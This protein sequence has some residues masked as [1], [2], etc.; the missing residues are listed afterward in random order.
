MVEKE[1]KR[2]NEYAHYEQILALAE[3]SSENAKQILNKYSG[4][5]PSTEEISKLQALSL[6]NATLKAKMGG[7]LSSEEETRY[8]TLKTVFSNGEPSEDE[9]LGLESK[10]NALNTAKARKQVIQNSETFKADS[11]LLRFTKNLPSAEQLAEMDGLANEHKRISEELN[12]MRLGSESTGNAKGNGVFLISSFIFIALII[13]GAI[14]TVTNPLF[15]VLAG[16]GAV[17]TAVCLCLF[18]V[19]KSGVNSGVQAKI[20]EYSSKQMYLENKIEVYLTSF[21]YSL[22]NG[23][24]FAYASFKKDYQS[25]MS[26]QKSKSEIK[27]GE[28]GIDNEISKLSTELNSYF[29]SYKIDETNYVSALSKLKSKINE[30]NNLKSRSKSIEQTVINASAKISENNSVISNFLSTYGL[31][32]IDFNLILKDINLYEREQKSYNE[33]TEKARLYKEEKGITTKPDKSLVDLTELSVR[34]NKLMDEQSALNSEIEND[35]RQ[36]EM[37]SGYESD[38]AQA[39]Q[40]LSEYNKTYD[41]LTAT[42]TLLK[43]AEQNLKDR[44]VKPVKDEFIKYSTLLESTLGEKVTMTKD[45]EVT[46]ERNGQERGEKYLSSG[47]KSICALCFRLALIKN[48]YKGTSPFLIMDDPFVFLDNEHFEKVEKVVKA[49]SK[50]M[51]IIYFT[52]H[53]SRKIQ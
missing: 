52:C 17:G 51:Q 22:A 15:L 9:L 10:I 35:E 25:F 44:Y 33:L 30:Y 24:M 2:I 19:K 46:F 31:N 34:L 20:N 7:G 50:E 3:T 42:S 26:L 41:L 11:D 47:V 4:K 12:A 14:L 49:L 53:E 8:G 48:M 32:S 23:V 27:A 13:L 36:V 43:T 39:E 6:E 45:F 5:L 16:V 40:K 29:I 1:N 18:L 28:V 21:G 37:L 38:K